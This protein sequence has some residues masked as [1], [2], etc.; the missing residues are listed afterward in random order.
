MIRTHYG[1]LIFKKNNSLICSSGIPIFLGFFSLQLLLFAYLFQNL[2]YNLFGEA[3]FNMLVSSLGFSLNRAISLHSFIVTFG[4]RGK[5]LQ[6][7][8][9]G[10]LVSL[11]IF[12]FLLSFGVLLVAKHCFIG[13]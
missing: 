9:C 2:F 4:F 13:G 3:K 12:R 1:Y 10:A 6:L 8:I 5:L 11:S 7:L